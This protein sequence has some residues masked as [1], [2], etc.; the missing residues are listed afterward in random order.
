[1]GIRFFRIR[2]AA[3]L[4]NKTKWCPFLYCKICFRAKDFEFK[5]VKCSFAGKYCAFYFWHEHIRSE[6]LYMYVGCKRIFLCRICFAAFVSWANKGDER[7]YYETLK[8]YCKVH[9]FIYK[10]LPCKSELRFACCMSRMGPVSAALNREKMA[11][12]CKGHVYLL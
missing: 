6:I 5:G 1:M 3:G 4:E 2:W 11:F 7:G 8:T 9:V 12:S 10:K